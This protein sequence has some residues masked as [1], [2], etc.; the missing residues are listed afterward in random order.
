MATI[1]TNVADLQA[2]ANNMSGDYEL[3]ANI[4]LHGVNWIPLGASADQLSTPNEFTGT[5]DGKGYKIL[6]LTINSNTRAENNKVGLF[7]SLGDC[8]ISNLV[9]ENAIITDEGYN[10]HVGI[11]AG[12]AYYTKPTITNVS[13]QG[14]LWVTHISASETGNPSVA[15]L[16]GCLYGSK[17][18]SIT[19]CISTVEMHLYGCTKTLYVAGFIGYGNKVTCTRCYT[20]GS[21]TV[22]NTADSGIN[23]STMQAV[24]YNTEHINCGTAVKI[25]GAIAN[26]VQTCGKYLTSS[27]EFTGSR[28]LWDG[29]TVPYETYVDNKITLLSQADFIALTSGNS[30]AYNTENVDFANGKYLKLAIDKET[31]TTKAYDITFLGQTFNG[32]K[33]VVYNGSVLKTLKL[34]STNYNF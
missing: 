3:G 17:T 1:I 34:N 29:V 15:G 11:L 13:V 9:I 2:V 27:Q 20:F 19:D 8:T 10:P 6:N 30:A 14:E 22:E 33:K 28:N 5:F 16:I 24:C 23:V 26:T 4:D 7:A 18:V 32:V 25:H 21:I 31:E 12:R